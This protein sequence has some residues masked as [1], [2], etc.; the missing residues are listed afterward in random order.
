MFTQDPLFWKAISNT[1]YY[2]GFRVPLIQVVAFFLA[3]LLSRNLRFKSLFRAGLYLPVMVPIVAKSVIWRF[4][5]GRVGVLNYALIWL[6]LP[7]L[8]LL[9][10]VFLGKTHSSHLQLMGRG[11]PHD[12]S[13]WP[14]FREF[15]NISLNRRR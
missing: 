13:T 5:L 2:V 9:S 11:R 8:N 10:S 14:E 12:N 1:I 3:V 7:T 4:L 15:R 6:G